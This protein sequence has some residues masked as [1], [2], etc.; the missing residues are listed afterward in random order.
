MKKI[1][2]I[3][4][5]STGVMLP[6]QA[7]KAYVYKNTGITV[8]VNAEKIY[9]NTIDGEQY[10]TTETETIAL[11]EIDSISTIAPSNME[12]NNNG[13]ENYT[14]EIPINENGYDRVLATDKDSD[15]VVNGDETFWENSKFN[16]SVTIVY[17]KN[18]AEVTTSDSSIKSYITGADVTLD[19]TDCGAVE[20]ITY[21]ATEDG[22]LK[23]YGKS[24]V[25]LTMNGL[26][27]KSAKSA[28]IN[29]QNKSTLYLHLND[30]TENYIC[31]ASSQSDESYYPEGVTASDEKRNGALYCKGSLVVS[32]GGL[33]VLD[34]EKKHGISVK[35]S[36]TI[37]AGVTIAVND[38]ADN[39]IKA[40]G[41]T[42]LGG[43]IWAK[44]SAEAGKCISSDADITV[45]G[46][47]LKLYTSGGSIYDEDENDTSSPSGIKADGNMVISGGNIHCV[48]TGEGGKGISTDGNLTID[49]GS[50]NVVTSGGKYVYNAALDLDSSPKGVKADGEII[51]NGGLL[52]IQV[53]GRSDGSEGLE[54][55]SKIT[56]NDGEVFVYAYDDAINVGGDYPIGIEINGGKVFAFADNNDGIDSNGKLWINGGLVIAS[57]SAAPEEGLDCDNSQNFIV[58]GGTLIG[59]GGAAISLSG[60]STQRAVIYNGVSAT[61]GELFVIVD[62]NGTPILKYEMPRTM[63]KLTLFFSSPDIKSG[64]SYTVYTGGL[65]NG[66]TINWNG[67]FDDGNY[68]VGTL[69][70][71]FT[72]SSITTTVGQSGGSSGGPGNGGG[73]FG[74]GW[75]K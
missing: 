65:L 56:I 17:S 34:G 66:N 73:G 10:M 18:S 30:D 32:G 52:N 72:S 49:A 39:C 67:W 20:I 57:G 60:S 55:K 46:G 16:T 51:I 35:S 37:R 44:T 69:L 31:D 22:Q 68:T 15:T 70:G 6:I 4:A 71:T 12:G 63:N 26:Y 48:S 5:I 58:T 62:T 13:E 1:L 40:E 64:G 9:F 27:L 59:T 3:I 24:A 11:N 19:L 74:P 33:L 61:T 7:Q 50:I 45:K 54:S 43:Y 29:V 25:K 41:V 14:P 2:T 47:V 8:G 36:A 23:V 75:W 42:I 53:T 28:A 38:V 21:G